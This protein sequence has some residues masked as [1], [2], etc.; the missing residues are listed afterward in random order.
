MFLILLIALLAF[1]TSCAITAF[2][3]RTEGY[4]RILDHPN[5]RSMH[6]TPT[7][8]TGGLAIWA[9]GLVGLVS[10]IA[11]FGFSPAIPWFVGAVLIVGGISLLDDHSHVP[12]TLRLAAHATASTL[13]VIGGLGP[14][15]LSLPGIRVELGALAVFLVGVPFLVW[16]IN[17]Y[18]FMDGMDGLAGGMAVLGFS[19]FGILG[20]IAGD[21]GFAAASFAV[22]AAATGFLV[23][24]FPPARIFMGDSG[25]SVLGLLAGA[26]SLWAEHADLF[27]L[28]V[29]VLVFSPFIVDASITLVQRTLRGRRPWEAHRDHYYQR[30]VRAGW[31]QCRTVLCWYAMML[32]SCAAALLAVHVPVRI[33]WLIF[34]AMTLVYAAVA[35]SVH[36]LELRSAQMRRTRAA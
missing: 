24:N 36:R 20:V 28:W 11:W 26:F 14:E 5:E 2:L 21:I 33:Q 7:P 22:A 32:L 13:L 25:A 1:G 29:A 15:T 30:L 16:M 19:A 6:A 8:R 3:I 34:A 35:F 10:L 27:P 18:N 17:L 12:V 23:W 4:L 31:G 9:G